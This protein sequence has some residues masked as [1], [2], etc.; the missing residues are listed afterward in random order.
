MELGTPYAELLEGVSEVR[1]ETG[2]AIR[3]FSDFTPEDLAGLCGLSPQQARRA[4]RRGY[5]EPVLITPDD[6]PTVSAV[7]AVLTRRGLRLTR[8][9]L[10]YHVTGPAD[11]GTAVNAVTRMMETEYG[12]VCT[13]AIGDS[14][15]DLPMLAA[16]D[17]AYIVQKPDGSYDRDLTGALKHVHAIPAI[18]PYGWARAVALLLSQG[19]IGRH[20]QREARQ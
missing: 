2:V 11:K 10:F 5:D 16:V 6:A 8:G 15:N 9:G 1:R 20:S 17:A 13:A 12:R 18:G 3:G 7:E 14:A 4:K 19:T